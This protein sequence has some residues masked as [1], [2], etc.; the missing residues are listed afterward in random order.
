MEQKNEKQ[1]IYFTDLLFAA[2]RPWKAMIVCGLVFALL[3]AG[4]TMVLTPGTTVG[5]ATLTPEIQARVDHLNNRIAFLDEAIAQQ[6]EYLAN[7]PMVTMDVY[8][9][10]SYGYHLYVTPVFEEQVSDSF[11]SEAATSA[12]IRAYR[13]AMMNSDSLNA[14][15]DQAGIDRKYIQEMVHNDFSYTGCFGFYVKCDTFEQAQLLGEGLKAITDS[16]YETICADVQNHT[17]GYIPFQSGPQH[18]TNVY[19]YQVSAQQDLTNYINEKTTHEAELNRYL[20][21]EIPTEAPSTK[22]FAAVGLVL[23]VFIAACC[24][25]LS[26]I[27]GGKIFSC[28]T[29]SNRTGIWVLGAVMGK[30]PN[31]IDRI[32]RKLE[33]RALHSAPEAVAVNIR[34]LCPDGSSLLLMGDFC[35]DAMESLAEKLTESGITCHLCPDP[36]TDPEALQILPTCDQVVLVETCCKSRYEAVEWAMKTVADHNK[37]LLGCVLIDG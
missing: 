12:L 2:L 11:A 20:P 30:K 13:S 1:M 4:Y 8:N 16:A 22:L 17:V 10:Y 7:A 32:L 36:A 34:N 26:Y 5:T 23:G 33:G 29:L 19:S 24:G 27:C 31:F 9:V 37:P 28:R 25:C 21:T 14:L 18:D 3:L 15:A 6:N 35:S